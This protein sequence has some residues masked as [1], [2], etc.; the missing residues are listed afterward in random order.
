ME[1]GTIYQ[2]IYR[3]SVGFCLPWSHFT[4]KELHKAQTKAHRAFVAKSGYNRNTASSVL[5]G[6]HYLGGAG[7]FHLYDEQGYG[8]VKLFMKSWRSPDSLQGRILRVSLAWAQYNAGIGV[9]ILE[10]TTTKLPH[11]ESVYLASLQDYLASTGGLL[12]LNGDFVVP[13]Q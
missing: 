5:F 12:E 1:I 7:F 9:S 11:L 2:S 4:E 3:P 6:P 8:Q 10:D 13:K